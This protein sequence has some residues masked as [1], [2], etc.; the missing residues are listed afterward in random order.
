MADL[1]SR[2]PRDNLIRAVAAPRI[3]LRADT[4]GD[5]GPPVMS[6]HFAVLNTWTEINSMWEGNFL[7]RFAPGSFKKTIREQRDK[8][9]VLFQHGM[10]PVLGDKPLGPIRELKED[11]EGAYYEVPLL[12]AP[13]VR[14]NVLPGLEA[15]LYGA[16]FRF[17]VMREEWVDEPD[18]SDDNPRGLPERT[19]KEAQVA[20]FGPVTFPA[21]DAATAGVRS[22]T[23]D[24]LLRCFEHDPAKL[25]TMF[26]E[27]MDSEDAGTL[28]EMVTLA[29]AYIEDQDEPDEQANVAAMQTIQASLIQLLNVEAVED[30]PDEPED[31]E[32]SSAPSGV[33]PERRVQETPSAPAR[34]TATRKGA[35]NYL[36]PRKEHPSWQLP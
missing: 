8:M 29:S 34:V 31:E 20:E 30:E 14:E 35:S 26:D 4:N 24:F 13:Y 22:L 18:P 10:D 23:D 5:A 7:E 12:D 11:G 36:T 3:E 27:R 16:S 17:K 33:T 15:D 9:K 21:Y 2:P 19:V 32:N 25:R 1:D 6:G 28:A